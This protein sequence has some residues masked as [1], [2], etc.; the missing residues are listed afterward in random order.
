[1]SGVLGKQVVVENKT[2][3]GTLV[4]TD[5]AAKQP[6]DGYTLLVGSTSNLAINPGLYSRLP[7]N[8]AKDFVLIRMLV[9]VPFMLTVNKDLP[10]NSLAQFVDYA[11]KNPGKLNYGSAGNGSG[12][13]IA[14]ALLALTAKINVQHV[15]YRGAAAARNDLLAGRIQ[16]LVDNAASIVSQIEGKKFRAFATTGEKRW[17]KMPN[18]PTYSDYFKH[19]VSLE[20]W[21]GIFARTGTPK[22]IRDKLASVLDKVMQDKKILDRFAAIGY[23]RNERSPAEAEAYVAKEMKRWPA[24]LH[25]A[26]IR[27]N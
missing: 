2:G 15:P 22:A 20:A 18:L 27:I 16:F 17:P 12:Q 3:S 24:F 6:P 21:F 1:M 5:Y 25:E 9:S 4:G 7:Y 10:I 23:V 11:R 14:G 19:D 13:H 26:K 8:P